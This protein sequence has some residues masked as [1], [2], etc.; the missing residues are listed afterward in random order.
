[1]LFQ[2]ITTFVGFWSTERK[3]SFQSTPPGLRTDPAAR[4]QRRHPAPR[5]PGPGPGPTPAGAI[6]HACPDLPGPARRGAQR[7]PCPRRPGDGTAAARWVP[8]R[9][10]GSGRQPVA[11]AGPGRRVALLGP[12][13]RRRSGRAVLRRALWSA[14][15][16]ATCCCRRCGSSGPCEVTRPRAGGGGA[17]KQPGGAR[18][19]RPSL[20]CA[21]D[22]AALPPHRRRPGAGP[23]P[24]GPR[25]P[26][27]LGGGPAGSFP[28]CA[29]LGAR[30]GALGCPES[31]S[32]IAGPVLLARRGSPR[33]QLG[34]VGFGGRSRP[35]RILLLEAL[36]ALPRSR[37]AGPGETFGDG[38]RWGLVALKH[39]QLS[40]CRF[41]LVSPIQL[42]LRG[43]WCC[44]RVEPSCPN[45]FSRLW[46]PLLQA[47][48][49]DRLAPPTF[50][51]CLI[52][53]CGSRVC[54][55]VWKYCA[56]GICDKRE[57]CCKRTEGACGTQCY[58]SDARKKLWHRRYQQYKRYCWPLCV[59]ALA[60]WLLQGYSRKK[61]ICR[62]QKSLVNS[63]DGYLCRVCSKRSIL[64]SLML[65]QVERVPVIF[66]FILPTFKSV[67]WTAVY[68]YTY[69][70]R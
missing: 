29:A 9:S 63:R 15:C 38:R 7:G 65:M 28:S 69:N 39:L 70:H 56:G 4:R 59:T 14:P 31:L 13:R 3:L 19:A 33:A 25:R 55:D 52:S 44:A 66:C 23:G 61:V 27:L 40:L 18:G 10:R 53:F 22:A 43:P 34:A 16:S 49:W 24:W 26:P 64:S 5:Q 36:S 11:E 32:G 50:N 58:I 37:S 21:P 57:L 30:E 8:A 54:N 35:S 20:R 12:G 60:E 47:G 2:G 67:M 1:M 68:I 6:P 45:R 42:W 41:H 17:G 48:H 46:Q 51:S 62:Q